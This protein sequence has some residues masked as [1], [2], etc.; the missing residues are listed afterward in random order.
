M[1]P[2]YLGLNVLM[3]QYTKFHIDS[4]AQQIALQPGKS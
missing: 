1:R 2:F 3:M 4:T